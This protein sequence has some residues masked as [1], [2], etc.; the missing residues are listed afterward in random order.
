MDAATTELLR[1]SIGRAVRAPGTEAVEAALHD[2]GWRE[3]LLAEGTAAVALLFAEQGAANATSGAIDDVLAA[4]LGITPG[5]DVAVVLPAFGRHTPPGRVTDG[6]V[7]LAGLGTPR[8]MKAD[9]AVVVAADGDG[10]QAALVPAAHL[11]AVPVG[12]ID[13]G[14]GLL[15]VEGGI[16]LSDWSAAAAVDWSAAVAAGQVALAYELAGA[17]RAM[18]SLAVQHAL[19]RVQFDRPIASFQAVR[20]RLADSLLAIEAAEAAT[21]QAAEA[22]AADPVLAGIAKAL[23]GRGAR[24]AAGHCQQVLA[25]IGFTTE[26]GFHHHLRRVLA[27]D[28]LLGDARTLTRELGETLVRE[29]RLPAAPAL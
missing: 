13:P 29:R 4:A 6:R 23:A 27:L 21:N 15:R 16:D 17:G 10:H 19:T 5:P 14:L 3:A 2:L 25:G 11:R 24:T 9:R 12:G 26:H 20:H 28:G 18:L 8:L 1:E 7:G 22:E